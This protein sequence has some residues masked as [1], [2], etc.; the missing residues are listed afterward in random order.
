MAYIDKRKLFYYVN[1]IDSKLEGYTRKINMYCVGGTA[2]TLGE[3]KISSYE[4]DFA[5]SRE[6]F[7]TLSGVTA[8]IERKERVRIDLMPEGEYVDYFLPYDYKMHAKK[9]GLFKNLNL[10]ILSDLDIVLMKA[11]AGRNKDY[12]HV[13][14]L[15]RKIKPEDLLKRFEE[16][17]FKKEKKEALRE[18]LGKSI[19]KIYGA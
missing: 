3:K 19:K 5:V 16:L 14:G 11:L 8:E 10:Y 12:V 15:K 2:L 1:L 13:E 17:K 18:K 4:M 6:D 7:R 9:I